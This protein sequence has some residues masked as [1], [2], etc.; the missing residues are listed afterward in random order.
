MQWP[1]SAPVLCPKTEYR[2]DDAWRR[3]SSPSKNSL[4]LPACLL[5]PYLAWPHW[6]TRLSTDMS[7]TPRTPDLYS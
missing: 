4:S 2:P 1:D 5:H 7:P 3:P 6:R